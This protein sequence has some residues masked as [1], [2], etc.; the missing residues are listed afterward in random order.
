RR[1][2]IATF[3]GTALVL[4]YGVIRV[5]MVDADIA[6]AKKLKM[7]LV[8]ADIGIFEKQAKGLDPKKRALT[9]HRNL[10]KHQ[11]MSAELEAAGVD[12]VVWPESSY[13]PLADPLIKRHDT[14]AFA[15]TPAGL[16][17]HAP[18]IASA[19]AGQSGWRVLYPG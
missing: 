17:G 5:G 1:E 6:E 11:H 14:R 13:F 15:L 7:G 16:S 8:E 12:L 2:L 3:A 9:L 18:A 10:I 4:L 19:A